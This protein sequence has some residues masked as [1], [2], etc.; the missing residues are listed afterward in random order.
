MTAAVIRNDSS[1]GGMVSG[2]AP[3]RP[4]VCWLFIFKDTEPSPLQ[5]SSSVPG[6]F[7]AHPGRYN[8]AKYFSALSSGTGARRE[9]TR[10]RPTH[11]VLTPSHTLPHAILNTLQHESHA[12]SGRSACRKPEASVGLRGVDKHC[13][14][15]FICRFRRLYIDTA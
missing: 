6:G 10:W 11:L 3:C 9:D 8:S 14:D 5:S 13:T 7:S 1:G 2:Q 15:M 12:V 4:C